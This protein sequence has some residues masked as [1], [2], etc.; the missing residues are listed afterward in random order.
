VAEARRTGK[1]KP[2]VKTLTQTEGLKGCSLFFFFSPETL[3]RYPS[4]KYLWGI[5]SELVPY[6]TMHLFLCNVVPRLWALFTGENDKFGDEQPWVISK[7]VCEAAG[8]EIKVGRKT[9]PL[10]QA[11][12][13]RDIS[14]HSGSYKAV[15][16]LYFLLSVGEVVLS[17]RIPEEYF[18]TFMLLSRAGRL[19]FKPSF[20]TDGELQEGDR[21]IKRF[22]HAFY[23]LVYAG[24]AD[25]IRVCRPTVVA[26]LDVTANLRSCG[27]ARSF[28]QLPTE[29]LLG[30][31][32][33]L[34]RSRR[35]PYAA[36]TK[37][38]SSKY[39]AELV[40]SFSEAQVPQAWAEATGKPIRRENQDPAVTFS[41]SKE[42][43]VDLLPSTRPAAE[44]IGE[45]L[46]RMTAVMR[47]EGASN[48]PEQIISKKYF[49]VRLS[50]GQIAGMLSSPEEA[51]DRRRDHLVRVS[52]V[53]RQSAR[54]GTG[55]VRVPVSVYGAVLHY[56]LVMIDDTP[57]TFA[58]IE[59]IKSSADRH[60]ASGLAERRRNTECFSSLGGAMR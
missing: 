35:F 57:M 2:S 5:G 34:I 18:N 26:L 43:K 44:L 47:L 56:T 28:W 41:L 39:P 30:T 17:D 49:R 15:D 58:Y 36:L 51:G 19:L 50:N 37:A 53:V 1:S 7:V 11:R 42:S 24:Q 25:L 21:L 52:S 14:K 59:W 22:S 8:R 4:L 9:V 6:D 48:V 40:T 33:R 32:S 20:M 54:R 12:S 23:T 55:E 16:W 27:P 60:G 3:A 13:L 10:S 46:T 45:E 29:R 38:V 31:L